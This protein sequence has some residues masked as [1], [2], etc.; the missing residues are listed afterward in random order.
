MG[1]TSVSAEIIQF[2]PRPKHNHVPAGFPGLAFHSTAKLDDRAE[3]HAD[4]SPC[5]YVGTSPEQIR[6][7]DG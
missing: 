5:D 6:I 7:E 2:M 3:D 1:G 4:T